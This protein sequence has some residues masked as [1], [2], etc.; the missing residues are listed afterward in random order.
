LSEELFKGLLESSPAWGAGFWPAG[1]ALKL[2]ALAHF[3]LNSHLSWKDFTGLKAEPLPIGELAGEPLGQLG[4]S[5]NEFGVS[6]G[7]VEF[8][9]QTQYL[10]GAKAV[11][12]HTVDDSHELL[13]A[14]LDVIDRHGIKTTAFVTTGYRTL[15]PKLW[16]R[17]RQA[18]TNGHEIGSHSRRHPCRIPD[19][20]FYCFRALTWNEI[21]GSRNDIL[22]NTDQPYVWSWAYPCGNC[23]GQEFIQR[24]IAQAGYLTARGY[25]DELQN[26]HAVPDLQTYDSNPYAARYTQVVQ[27]GY[28]KVVPGKGEVAISGRTDVSLLNAKFDE[29][30]AGGGIYSFLS[31]P[32][33]IDYGPDSFYERH[34]AH[35]AGREDIWYV[36][37]G[38]LYAYRTLSE[39]TRIEALKTAGGGA[40]FVVFNQ[41]DRKVYNG[42]ITLRFHSGTAM[43]V[44]V[45]GNELSE[46]A[47]G[48]A[49]HWDEQYFR[50]DG[51]DL[52]VTVR[53]N[54]VVEFRPPNSGQNPA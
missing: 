27:K 32:Q 36:P 21:V 50:R 5:T 28:S 40:R 37:M 9:G 41:L 8:L 10:N 35:I 16:P 33:M 18:I 6:T 45:N 25:P 51:K 29:V 38:P 52:L 49:T 17:L 31:H 12:S 1:N 19:T 3:A 39:Q 44:K 13:P 54:S 53:P 24:K 34:L 48:P 7:P 22:E 42:S 23:A 20:A 11:V 43:Q 2:A 14:C 26:L 15:M 4:V 46:R 30:L 47:T